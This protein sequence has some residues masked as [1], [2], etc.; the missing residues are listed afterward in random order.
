MVVVEEVNDTTIESLMGEGDDIMR[1]SFHKHLTVCLF[2]RLFSRDI[3]HAGSMLSPQEVAN[4]VGEAIGHSSL[5]PVIDAKAPGRINLIGEHVDYMGG[6]V[7]PA[8]LPMTCRVV[9]LSRTGLEL[10]PLTVVVANAD[11]TKLDVSLTVLPSSPEGAVI[12]QEKAM[13]TFVT[14][15]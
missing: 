4:M 13:A 6:F 5:T 15:A 8:A 2:V 14:A 10:A 11:H 12:A 9:I 3:I 1:D 7:L